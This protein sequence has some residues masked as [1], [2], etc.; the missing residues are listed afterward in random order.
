MCDTCAPIPVVQSSPETKNCVPCGKIPVIPNDGFKPIPVCPGCPPTGTPVCV[1]VLQPCECPPPPP[2]PRR[3][4]RYIQPPRPASFRPEVK[5]RPPALKME[6]DTIYRKS[7]LP[8][9]ADKPDLILPTHNLCLGEGKIS[10]DTINRM[11]YKEHKDVLPPCL[12]L[13]CEHKLIGE[14]PMQDL[15]TQKH[16]Y[17]PKP[18]SKVEPIVPNPHLFTSDCPLSDQTVNRLSYMPVD[19]KKAHVDPVIPQTTLKA[20]CGKMSDK[21]IHK[22]SFLP[23][24]PPPAER[25][26]WAEKPK[27]QP[28]CLRMDGNTINKMSYQPPGTYVECPP[29]CPDA[30]DCPYD[31]DCP[32]VHT[33]KD[34]NCCMPCCCPKAAC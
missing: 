6:D 17:V 27:Y 7:Y 29:D 20:P 19:V 5:Y 12:I 3:K 21:T 2:K 23:W 33:S 4:C 28:P 31:D 14:G 24:E 16:D 9:D 1:P 22:M 30:V 8:V 13:P 11:S 15:T 10:D 25:L 26:P 34:P 32:P 18:F